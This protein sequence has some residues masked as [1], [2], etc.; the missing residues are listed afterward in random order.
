MRCREDVLLGDDGTAAVVRSVPVL[1]H[2]D[3][4]LEG[5]KQ[6]ADCERVAHT[7]DE[8]RLPQLTEL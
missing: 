5:D 1:E 4:R 3:L 2:L 6:R 7:E 8:S